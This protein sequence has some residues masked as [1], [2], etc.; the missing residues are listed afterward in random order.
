MSAA[1]VSKAALAAPAPATADADLVDGAG[2]R[3]RLQAMAY[4]GW[5]PA[6][7]GRELNVPAATVRGWQSAAWVTAR[8]AAKVS[9]LYDRRWNTGPG[10]PGNARQQALA[11]AARAEA[12][13][14]RWVPALA[15][16]DD[17]IDDPAAS[18]AD[19]WRRSKSTRW[20]TADL[21]AEY[22]DL[23]RTQGYDRDGAAE[24]L[25]VTRNT[26]DQALLRHRKA[27]ELALAAIT[28]QMA[29]ETEMA[30]LTALAQGVEAA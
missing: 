28:E 12:N 26:L 2:T 29:A 24:R 16:D 20:K 14:R 13:A 4:R 3:R 6:A 5:W 15:W 7:L 22:K 23:A 11:A 1:T 27:E 17:E 10:Q 9:A 19:N 18:P 25:G 21:V 30:A 8:T